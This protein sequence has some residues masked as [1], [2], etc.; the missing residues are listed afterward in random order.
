MGKLAKG[1]IRIVAKTSLLVAC[2]ASVGL[3]AHEALVPRSFALTAYS[4]EPG[5]SPVPATAGRVTVTGTVRQIGQ[6]P[7]PGSVPYK[8]CIVAIHLDAVRAQ[9]PTAKIGNEVVVFAWGLRD[10]KLLPVAGYRAG[11]RV[12]L[13]L[14]PWEEVEGQYGTYNRVELDDERLFQLASYWADTIAIS[15]AT[16]GASSTGSTTQASPASTSLVAAPAK[17]DLP[18]AFARD[19]AA[20]AAELKASKQNTVRGRDGWLFYGPELRS[21]SSGRFW[22]AD[23]ARVTR[24]ANRQD[25]DPLPAILDFAQQLKSAGIELIVVPVP[26]KA[27]IYPDK[28]SEMVNVAPGSKPPRLDR[29]LQEFYAILRNSGL[30]VLDLTSEMLAHR[31]DP[32]GPMFCRQD[33]HWSPRAVRFVAE[34]IKAT[35]ATRPWLATVPKQQYVTREQTVTIKGDLWGFLGDASLPRETLKAV[36]V[37]KPGGAPVESWRESPV[38]LLGDSHN[39]IYNAGGDMQATGAGLPDQLAVALGFP[40]DLVSIRGSGATP[41]RISLLRRRDSLAGKKLVVWCFTCREFTEAPGGWAKVPVI[42]TSARQVVGGAPAAAPKGEGA[43]VSTGAGDGLTTVEGTLVRVSALPRPEASDYPDCYYTAKIESRA[44]IAGD[45]IERVA[46]VVLPG[47]FDRKY[48]PHA[49]LKAGDRVRVVLKPFQKAP[50]AV[51]QVQQADDIDEFGL[52]YYLA[53]R[54][55]TINAFSS[56]PSRVAFREPEALARG[57][58]PWADVDIE[59]HKVRSQRIREDLKQI[60]SLLARHRGDW[61]A[62]YD[63]TERYRSEYRRQFELQAQMWMGDSFFSAGRV[64]YE[65]VSHP[66]FVKSVVEFKRYLEK[67]GVDLILVRIPYKGEIVPDLFSSLP[68][69]EVL[70]PRLLRLYKDLLEADVEI[71]ADVVPRAMHAR[72]EYPLMYW[73]QAFDEPHPAEGMSWVLAK[74]VAERVVRY[75]KVKQAEKTAYRLKRETQPYRDFKWP[76]GNQKFHPDDYVSFQ[77]V[78]HSDGTPL[79]LSQAASSPILMA[80]SSFIA[81]PSLPKAASVPHYLAYLTGVAPDIVYRNG[82]EVGIPRSVAI[83][84]DKFL[85]NRA[86]LVY[87]FHPYTALQGALSLPPMLNPTEVDKQLLAVIDKNNFR[88]SVVLPPDAEQGIFEFTPDGQLALR[89]FDK[90]MGAK[91]VLE[92]ELPQATRDYS[93]LVLEVTFAA[94]AYAVIAGTHGRSSDTLARSISEPRL[95]DYLVFEKGD[96]PRIQLDFNHNRV[97]SRENAIRITGFKVFGVK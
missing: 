32:D 42:A 78:T 80:G 41:A 95:D 67:R 91:G 53:E 37:S 2:V 72:M 97:F 82:Y 47:F 81:Y 33:T 30:S 44:V 45:P 61:D 49:H 3:V 94:K 60:D 25:A 90:E 23:A 8:D 4:P 31:D 5:S 40:V 28:I 65:D 6:V 79:E 62:W 16:G 39:L 54:I 66:A 20:K 58:A 77:A 76:D 13:S 55:E 96:G 24:S 36:V 18:G 46:V 93:T 29:T 10:A 22:G 19:L 7:Q 92:L 9:D 35:V 71:V 56:L 27:V 85:R 75:K 21:L 87:P 64:L 57:V 83:E 70:N 52:Q 84:G 73:Y 74:A 11:Q 43:L 1:G 86:V 38:V 34:R 89:S 59:A 88:E 69:G 12:V 68:P 63:A 51:K 26:A 48:A 50:Q 14:V 15:A 17:D